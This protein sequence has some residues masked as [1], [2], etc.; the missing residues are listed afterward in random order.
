M[1]ENTQTTGNEVR[2]FRPRLA[3]FKPNAKG[4]GC[5]MKVEL[6]PAHGQVDGS[7]MVTLANQMTIGDRRGPTP[8]YP[9]FDWENSICVK[10]DFNDL[11][12]MLLVL[13]GQCE[14]IDEGHGLV[15]QSPRG[16]THINLRHATEPRPC[17]CFE[18]R[19]VS[20]DGTHDTRAFM[21]LTP[22]EAA[23]LLAAIEGSL[24]VIC[25]GIPMVI[26]RNVSAYKQATR[27]MRY[28]K[29]SA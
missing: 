9:H 29:A 19:R 12:K 14:T 21:P 2:Q 17:F 18:V 20:G 3:F 28:G 25:F 24:S 6:H 1:N 10:L 15:H 27:E 23:G 16:R 13:R 11:S 7:L 26:E 22:A 4:S 5:A 8:V